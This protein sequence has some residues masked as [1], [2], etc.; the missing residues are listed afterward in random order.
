[1]TTFQIQP[2]KLPT[3]DDEEEPE[4]TAIAGA[5]A[6]EI[7]WTLPLLDWPEQYRPTVTS[8][9]ERPLNEILAQIFTGKNYADLTPEEKQSVDQRLPAYTPKLPE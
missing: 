2:G 9:T 7:R 8:A 3:A 1:V 4:L 5:G 6:E